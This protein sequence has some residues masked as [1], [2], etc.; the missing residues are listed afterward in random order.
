MRLIQEEFYKRV[1]YIDNLIKSKRERILFLENKIRV[2]KKLIEEYKK[3]EKMTKPAPEKIR[4]VKRPEEKQEKY[5]PVS[6][7]LKP[8]EEPKESKSADEKPTLRVVKKTNNRERPHQQ[9]EAPPKEQ[10]SAK[11]P[12]KEQRE[13]KLGFRNM[14]FY[15]TKTK[16]S[17]WADKLKNLADKFS[18]KEKPIQQQGTLVRYLDAMSA[19]YQ[20]DADLAQVK[21]EEVE[22]KKDQNKKTAFFAHKIANIGSALKDPAIAG[23][24]ASGSFTRLAVMASMFFTRSMKAVEEARMTSYELIEKTRIDDVDKA[25]QEAWNIYTNCINEKRAPGAIVNRKSGRFQITK[26]DLEDAYRKNLPENLLERL[27]KDYVPGTTTNLA[28]SFIKRDMAWSIERI[29]KK[30]EKVKANSSISNPE[31]DKKIKNILARQSGHLKELD[32]MITKYGT[33]DTI[34]LGARYATVAGK[35]ATGALVVQ[36]GARAIGNFWNNLPNIMHKFHTFIGHEIPATHAT[37]PIIETGSTVKPL[38]ASAETS[39]GNLTQEN[40]TPETFSSGGKDAAAKAMNQ[41]FDIWTENQRQMSHKFSDDWNIIEQK[42]PTERRALK[43]I[44]ADRIKNAMARVIESKNAKLISRYNLTGIKN[45]DSI[46]EFH[47]RKINWNTLLDDVFQNGLTKEIT[48]EK[49]RSI[50]SQEN[51]V[52]KYFETHQELART[53]KNYERVAVLY[54]KALKAAI[55]KA[56]K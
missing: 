47:L 46:Q 18:H 39:K 38:E 41:H 33:L 9:A 6:P 51:F 54:R 4:L 11:L 24:L 2:M 34:L 37:S 17:F 20:K 14:G 49:A 45:I 26:E 25:N 56:K 10:P 52:K 43:S 22:N 8:Q 44:N 16:N 15:W 32:S 13:I 7:T 27:K 31:K 12:E 42:D 28:M 19:S 1:I 35:T 40:I 3:R 48:P 36:S 50:I 53:S 23:A 30:I 29:N 55:A 21:L 5:A